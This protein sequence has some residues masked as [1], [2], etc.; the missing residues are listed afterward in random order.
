MKKLLLLLSA[1]GLL[2]GACSTPERTRSMVGS[3]ATEKSEHESLPI[4]GWTRA[5][6]EPV[7]TSARA[8]PTMAAN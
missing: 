5:G 1:S 2:L 4:K 8:V 3:P 6:F 7:T